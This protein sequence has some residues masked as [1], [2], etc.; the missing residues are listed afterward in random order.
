[1]VQ[2][3]RK[4]NTQQDLI[5]NAFLG[6]AISGYQKRGVKGSAYTHHHLNRN[7]TS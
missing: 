7:K 2:D 4:E 6:S 1:M 3:F 5:D